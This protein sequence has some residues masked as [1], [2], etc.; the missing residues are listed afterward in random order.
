MI[1]IILINL[2]LLLLPSVIYFGYVYFRR[3]GQPD[4][5]ILA[6][7]PIFWLLAGGAAIMLIA[8]VIL[9][10]WEVGEPGGRYVPPHVKDGVIIPGHIEHN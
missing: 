7:A 5:E 9:G 8:L 6:N 4:G 1:R 10:Q 2:L 3:R